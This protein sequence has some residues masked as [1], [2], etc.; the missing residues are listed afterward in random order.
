MSALPVTDIRTAPSV[1]RHAPRVV[2]I[3]LAR[4]GIQ[5][6]N[7]A[8][9][10]G[11]NPGRLSEHLN[12]ARKVTAEDIERWAGFF[13]VDP[14]LFFRD[15]AT[16]VGGPGTPTDQRSDAFGCTDEGEVIN[17]MPYLESQDTPLRE[18][19]GS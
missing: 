12:G 13:G 6:K 14:G 17:L 3:L 19:V 2:R 10:L 1:Q 16:L 11:I 4:D 7:M 18:A 8:A 5:Q 9:A 15:P